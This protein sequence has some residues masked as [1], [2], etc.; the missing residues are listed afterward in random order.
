MAFSGA[1]TATHAAGSHR[2]W[3][4]NITSAGSGAYAFGEVIF[5]TE[6][7]GPTVCYGGAAIESSNFSGHG[8]ANAFDGDPSTFWNSANATL[9]QWI[10]YDLGAGNAAAIVEVRVSAREDDAGQTPTTFDVQ[11][12]DD[13]ST[14]TTLWSVT[15]GTWDATPASYQSFTLASAGQSGSH[16]AYWRV[17]PT[18]GGSGVYSMAEVQF[19]ASQG[20]ASEATGGIATARLI[21]ADS[22]T[23]GPAAAFDGNASTFYSSTTTS[24]S[25]D[26]G[27]IYHFATPVGVAQVAITA[28]NDGNQAQ[29]PT[30]FNI[31]RSADGQTWTTAQSFTASSWSNG[32]TQ[33]FTLGEKGV[34]TLGGVA[35]SANVAR[36]EGLGGDLVL[37]GAAFSAEGVREEGLAGD[38]ALGDLAFSARIGHG[39]GF[40][41]ELALDAIAFSALAAR[42]ETPAGVLALQPIAIVASCLDLPAAGKGRRQFW[43]FGS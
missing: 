35:F 20:G 43:T 41:G 26:Q 34:L 16:Y 6:L 2:Y 14:W 22:Q 1:G 40:A 8:A 23:Y 9:P 19:R 38:L 39:E 32:Q 42:E 31:D 17:F 36:T 25:S 4:L 24:A 10:G 3:R 21:F 13:E 27:L 33:I 18:G 7:C 37:G 30:G 15:T 11:Y 5:A 28:R 29:T 12:S